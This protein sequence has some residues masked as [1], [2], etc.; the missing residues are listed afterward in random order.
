MLGIEQAVEE[1]TNLDQLYFHW[2]ASSN[3]KPLLFFED[4]V[5]SFAIFLG[6]DEL[7]VKAN[8]V[9]K[10]ITS[11]PKKIIV[12]VFIVIRFSFDD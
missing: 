12:F 8:A 3:T 9:D 6:E 11:A 4:V 2:S 7:L 1:E 10:T 5:S